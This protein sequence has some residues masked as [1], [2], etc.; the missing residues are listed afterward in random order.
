[1]PKLFLFSIHL[2][3]IFHSTA[4]AQNAK[5]SGIVQDEKGA[6]LEFVN[7]LLLNAED[8]T[9]LKGTISNSEGAFEVHPKKSGKF[10]LQYSAIGYLTHYT[11]KFDFEA[12]GKNHTLLTLQLQPNN[13][14]LEEFS[15]VAK[16][17]LFEQKIDRT[18]VNVSESATSAGATALEVLEKSPGVDVNRSNSQISMLGKNGVVVMI[19]GKI[20]RME[21]DGLLQLLQG[22]NADNIEKIELITTPPANFDAEGNAGIINIQTLQ[23]IRDGHNGS[24]SLNTAYGR[25]GRFGGSVNLIAGLGKWTVSADVS[26]NNRWT[27][28]NTFL[29]RVIEFN[30]VQTS[31]DI[32]SYRPAYT[33]LHNGSLTVDY[34][35]SDKTLVSTRLSGYISHWTLDAE[36]ET[37]TSNTMEGLTDFSLLQSDEI[38]HWTHWMTNFHLKHQF[39]EKSSIAL[40]YDYLYYFDDNPTDYSNQIEDGNRNFVEETEFISRKETPIIFQVAKLDYTTSALNDKVKIE[41]GLKGTFSTF[42]NDI[43]VSNFINNEWVI[44]PLFTTNL[45]LDENITAAYLS[46]DFSL[47]EN[48]QIKAGLRYEYIESDLSS[49]TEGSLLLQNYGTFFPTIY[50]SKKMSEDKQWQFSYNKRITRPPFNLMAPAFFFFAPSN[51]LAGNPAILPTFTQSVKVDYQLKRWM[52]SLQFSD[53]ENPFAWGQ[54]EINA[55]E[56]IVINKVQNMKDQKTIGFTSSFPIAVTDWWEGRYNLGVYYFESQ[57]VFEGVVY[58]RSDSYF[59]FNT[60]QSF[61]LPKKWELELGAQYRSELQ[62]GMGEIP[63][64]FVINVGIS[65]SLF[66]NKGKLTFNWS[67]VFNTGSFFEVDYDESAINLQYRWRYEFDGSVARLSYTHSFGSDKL[68]K[69]KRTTGSGDEQ[70]RVN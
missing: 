12:N 46:T 11:E 69:N 59:T 30:G 4:D 23:K 13:T 60:T 54:P 43:S 17:P 65:K 18:V 53:E 51:I 10:M 41:A 15:V 33:G 29:D 45:S 63:V 67:D 64:R 47:N 7:I 31:T 70:R 42:N 9:M 39:N 26:S 55:E 19:N 37:F 21:A 58:K 68:K 28:E 2:L 35:I 24:F 48:T 36:T 6:A 3:L 56:N 27:Q 1:M 52:F 22:M 61:Q 66:K 50:L 34:Q 44:E 38:N 32:N 5:I 14:L 40:D 16:K 57:P 49:E 20:N 25:R 8:S 62:Y